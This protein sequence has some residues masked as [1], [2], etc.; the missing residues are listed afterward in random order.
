VA[1][2][3]SLH[4]TLGRAGRCRRICT[5]RASYLARQIL[6]TKDII[7]TLAEMP[8]R[9]PIA[10]ENEAVD[11]EIRHLVFSNYRVLFTVAHESVQVLHVRNAATERKL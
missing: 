1:Q 10:V 7:A 6:L 5:A 2:D 3:R 9:C 8:E 11:Q 4:G